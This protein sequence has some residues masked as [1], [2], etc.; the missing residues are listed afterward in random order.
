MLGGL[1]YPQQPAPPL[2][3]LHPPPPDL[4]TVISQFEA[5][6]ISNAGGISTPT[7]LMQA[8]PSA[9]LC[10][11]RGQ[12]TPAVTTNIKFAGEYYVFLPIRV[13][14]TDLGRIPTHGLDTH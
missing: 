6:A 11:V 2:A 8:C 13:Q 1:S 5:A 4:S 12:R 14:S 9:P 7:L 3:V 10:W